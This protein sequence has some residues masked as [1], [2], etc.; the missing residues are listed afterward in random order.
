M[1]EYY[2]AVAGHYSR[3]TFGQVNFSEDAVQTLFYEA[4]GGDPDDFPADLRHSLDRIRAGAPNF[5]SYT[6]PGSR[7]CVLDQFGFYSV[8]VDDVPLRDWVTELAEGREV[9]HVGA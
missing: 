2:L 1:A 4:V 3:H 5:V 9:N 7:H 8:E 6:A